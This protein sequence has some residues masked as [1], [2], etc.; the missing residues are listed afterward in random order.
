MN[1]SLRTTAS[2]ANRKPLDFIQAILEKYGMTR[3]RSRLQNLILRQ[4]P[5]LFAEPEA[6]QP[7]DTVINNIYPVKQTYIHHS[8]Y[9]PLTQGRKDPGTVSRIVLVT[10]G[11]REA[12][13]SNP[14]SYPGQYNSVRNGVH[15][16]AGRLTSIQVLQERVR[17]Q[18]SNKHPVT[19][20]YRTENIAKSTVEPVSPQRA[21]RDQAR[22]EAPPS[23]QH[24][25]PVAAVATAGSNLAMRATGNRLQTDT[26]ASRQRESLTV[27]AAQE[28]R[29]Q[30]Q[31]LRTYSL[32]KE[33][34]HGFPNQPL[35]Q[36]PGQEAGHEQLADPP[37]MALKPKHEAV[38]GSSG[39][40]VE[41]QYSTPSLIFRPNPDSHSL[42]GSM[43]HL[44]L[45]QKLTAALE[46]LESSQ[47]LLTPLPAGLVA[48]YRRQQPS[49]RTLLNLGI[50]S[51]SQFMVR[52][53]ASAPL[54][55][56]AKPGYPGV[57]LSAAP[58][59]ALFYTPKAQALPS[60][61]QRR[62]S[63]GSLMSAGPE[64]EEYLKPAGS[65]NLVLRKPE[66]PKAARPEPVQQHMERRLP[67]ETVLLP[68][69]VF[70]K[71]APAAMD[72]AELNLLAERVYQVLEK[73]LAIRKDRRGLR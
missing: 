63:A 55:G 60:S 7:A 33:A 53:A 41:A 58:E 51:D 65:S 70:T 9:S 4:Y 17:K 15:S 48:V 26:G 24:H 12:A 50:S 42:A 8:V 45:G 37:A 46:K 67:E 54:T 22:T 73:K 19:T 6:L 20:I 2:A 62:R 61:S 1:Q 43:L 31:L 57:K 52:Q 36:K 28:V 10:Q 40:A 64:H 32:Y 59:S 39:T 21:E 23:R 68:S 29:H 30:L 11:S 13:G 69:Q 72:A 35:R 3:W 16:A 47:V 38:P 25:L 5:L 27:K 14:S 44:G 56:A 18:Q 71:A 66:A 49:L 34:A